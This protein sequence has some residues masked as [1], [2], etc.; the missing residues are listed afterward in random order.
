ME[1][2]KYPNFSEGSDRIGGQLRGDK[3][4]HFSGVTKSGRVWRKVPE[5][6][7][8]SVNL[9]EGADRVGGQLCG[10]K[11][12]PFSGV[13]KLWQSLEEGAGKRCSE[14]AVA[15]Y[16]LQRIKPGLGSNPGRLHFRQWLTVI[17]ELFL[18]LSLESGICLH[19][20]KS[21]LKPHL[22]SSTI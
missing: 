14:C 22:F 11:E 6:G 16:L 5:S 19:S 21:K 12:C 18:S 3:E 9:S 17:M 8:R 15:P 4:C 1:F 7:A 2:D 13:T 10:D 20:L